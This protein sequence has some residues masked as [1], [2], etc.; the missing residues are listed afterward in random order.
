MRRTTTLPFLLAATGLVAQPTITAGD[1]PTIGEQF[2]YASGALVVLPGGGSNQT[3]D[4]SGST[5]SSGEALTVIAASNGAGAADFP[6]AS[7]AL[8]NTNIEEYIGISAAGFEHHG[9]FIAGD[10]IV[11][12]DPEL[13]LP[14]PCVYGQ[15]WNDDFAGS[16]GNGANSFTGNITALASGYGTLILPGATLTNVLRVDQTQTRDENS[17][18]S[19]VRTSNIF[20]RPGTGYFVAN[21]ERLDT[22]YGTNPLAFSEEVTYLAAAG[23]GMAEHAADAIGLDLLP[24]PA[25]DA[26]SV[27]FGAGGTVQVSVF[28]AQ[29]RSVITTAM[30]TLVPGIHRKQLNVAELPTGIYTVRVSNTNGE[31]G[32]RRLVKD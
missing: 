13:Y 2:T 12:T 6:G 16:W 4:F 17:G 8:A 11:Y 10:G 22:Y 19:Y 18:F 31:H 29:G 5:G 26:V 28:D 3:W 25:T 23:I 1:A 21:N 30:G 7:V 24:N 15:S 20:Y 14:I 9:Q 32:T 27:V